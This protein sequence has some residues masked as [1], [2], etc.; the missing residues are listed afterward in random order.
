MGVKSPVVILYDANGVEMAIQNGVIVPAGTRALLM[1]AKDEDTGHT[2]Q[3]A[4]RVDGIA[5]LRV[6]DNE[7]LELLRDISVHMRK[8][9]RH[10]ELVTD[11]ENVEEDEA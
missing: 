11:E 9:V 8:L 1:A 7:Q 3:A 5:N 10:L 2:L 6:A 4:S